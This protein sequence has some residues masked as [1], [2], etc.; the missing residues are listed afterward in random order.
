MKNYMSGQLGGFTLIELLVVV[1]IIGILAAIALPKYEQAVLKS[2]MTQ[3]IVYARAVKDA[4]ERYY[5]ANG[6][7]ATDPTELDIDTPCPSRWICDVTGT[8][9]EVYPNN[10]GGTLTVIARYDFYS[11][12]AIAG[13]MYC[14]A[15]YRGPL[16][17]R[18]ICK[19]YGPLLVDETSG[20]VPGVS[21]LIQ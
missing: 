16:K 17:Y 5:L 10:V 18:N 14:W 19:S 20:S 12:A 6:I 7:Y 21:Y 11:V 2:R 13:K 8:K 4:Q 3:A 1:L 9:V 15:S